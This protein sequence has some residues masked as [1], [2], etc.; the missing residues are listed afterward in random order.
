MLNLIGSGE[1]ILDE[2]EEIEEDD[3]EEN[4][5]AK[6]KRYVR[7]HYKGSCWWKFLKRD[8]RPELSNRDGKTFRN[9]F[10]VPYQLCT[11]ILSTFQNEVDSF[12]YEIT[13][14]S[15]KL[16]GTLRILGKGCSWDLLYELSGV[17]AEVHI[18]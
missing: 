5:P 1:L 9:R 12:G 10:T 17:S 15:L 16:L 4:E 13:P 18:R 3:I 2:E 8:N 11:H 14:I 6:K 7:E